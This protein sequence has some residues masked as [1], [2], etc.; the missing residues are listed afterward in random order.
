VA[1]RRHDFSEPASYLTNSG[2]LKSMRIGIAS[3]EDVHGSAFTGKLSY[4]LAGEALLMAWE[5]RGNP[6]LTKEALRSQ[7]RADEDEWAQEFSQDS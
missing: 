3:H 5:V 4:R 1:C 2:T 6:R 7:R